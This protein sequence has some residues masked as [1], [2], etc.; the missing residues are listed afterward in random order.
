MRELFFGAAL[1]LMLLTAACK[2][3]DESPVLLLYHEGTEYRILDRGTAEQDGIPTY[4][5]R[6]Y[7]RDLHDEDVL[8]AERR[9]LLTIVAR[10]VNTNVHRRVLVTA[11]ENKSGFLRF[12]KPHEIT[13][14]F[15]VEEVREILSEGR[16]QTRDR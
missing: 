15:S 16:S 12:I 8:Q 6:Y 7:S 11:V 1:I 5:V 9:D 10:H 4:F 3:A 14:S 2:R 13:Q